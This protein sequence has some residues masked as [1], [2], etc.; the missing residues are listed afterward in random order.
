MYYTRLFVLENIAE[1]EISLIVHYFFL[2]TEISKLVGS[3]ESSMIYLNE[4]FPIQTN[5]KS[6]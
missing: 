5:F 2:P 3:L 6:I 1:F 4:M